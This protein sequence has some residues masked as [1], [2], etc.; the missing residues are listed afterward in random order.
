MLTCLNFYCPYT[1][2]R[3][4]SGEMSVTHD[5]LVVHTG[6]A[7]CYTRSR[8]SYLVSLYHTNKGLLEALSHN[9]KPLKMSQTSVPETVLLAYARAIKAGG[10][11]LTPCIY[12]Q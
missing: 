10:S 6:Y 4:N 11:Q 2:W 5:T 7:C 9:C 8:D 12:L 3:L 1:Q